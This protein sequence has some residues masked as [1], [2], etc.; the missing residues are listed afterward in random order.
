[1]PLVN[2]WLVRTDSPGS[3]DTLRHRRVEERLAQATMRLARRNEALED[4]AALVAHE[5]KTPLH[6]A[7]VADDASSAVERALELVDALLEA[8]RES[9][10]RPSASAAICLEQ[11]LRDLGAAQIAVTAELRAVLPLPPASLRVILRN[12]LRNAVA[13]GARRVDVA[14]ARSSGSWS[15]V[16]DDDGVGVGRAGLETGGS[17]LGLT[18]C[19]RIAGRYGG[20]L[21]LAPRPTGGT[22][23]TLQLREAS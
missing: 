7:L 9:S 17:G 5:L 19:S 12:L 6:E 18:L 23:A 3:G 8:A 16:V 15:L 21:E 14:A 2:V 13:A 20:V 1:M 22:R 11:A 10:E 4:F